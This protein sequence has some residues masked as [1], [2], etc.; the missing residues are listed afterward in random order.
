MDC[1][2]LGL[3]DSRSLVPILELFDDLTNFEP[4]TRQQYGTLFTIHKTLLLFILR[5][6]NAR[7]RRMVQTFLSFPRVHVRVL[8]VVLPRVPKRTTI[9]EIIV[10]PRVPQS[11]AL[12]IGGVGSGERWGR[13]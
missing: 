9:F 2:D 3:A 10:L 5:L 6:V 1:A 11:A 7:F 12:E 4:L 13:H 8:L